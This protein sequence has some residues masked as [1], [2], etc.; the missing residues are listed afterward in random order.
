MLPPFPVT[1][2]TIVAPEVVKSIVG[3]V[4]TEGFEMV[5]NF[6]DISAQSSKGTPIARTWKK[7]SFPADNPPIWSSPLPTSLVPSD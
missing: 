3:N 2:P 4:R 7:T 6:P 5:L 1:S